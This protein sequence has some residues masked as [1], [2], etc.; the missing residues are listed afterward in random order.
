MEQITSLTKMLAV[1]VMTE[2]G[3][4]FCV[5]VLFIYTLLPKDIKQKV[6]GKL[7]Y[8]FDYA[9]TTLLTA[10]F[11]AGIVYLSYPNYLDHLES[12]ITSLGTVLSH[13]ES[14]YPQ[15][16]FYPY[17]GLLYGPLLATIQAFFSQIGLPILFSSKIP[18]LIAFLSSIL[19]CLYLLK[20]QIAKGY[21]IYLAPFGLMLFWNRAEPFFL[22]L[23]STTLLLTKLKNQTNLSFL[24]AG[25]LTGLASALKLHG[26]FYILSAYLVVLLGITI[27]T[28]GLL[29]FFASS[30]VAFLIFFIP[31]NISLVNFFTYLKL[32]STH[33]ISYKLWV[34]N[35][36]YFIFLVFPILAMWDKI[37]SNKNISYKIFTVI[38]IE[39]L[40]TF[41][42]AK[43][44][45]G[46][47]HMLPF[48]PVNAY[49][50]YRLN[51][52]LDVPCARILKII[53]FSL[54]FP[55]V[56]AIATVYTPL[57]KTW[58]DFGGAI[59]ELQSFN[60]EYPGLVM[61]ITDYKNYPYTFLR[62]VLSGT[63]ID[64]ASYMD[65]QFAGV[66]DSTM[67]KKME[68]CTIKYI[69]LPKD[70]I[71]FSTIN[72]YTEEYLFSLK[73]QQCFYAQYKPI[74][75]RVYFNIYKCTNKD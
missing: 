5:T 4:F 67:V 64:Y 58:N 73:I 41:I 17:H 74:E 44:G 59:K 33:G 46:I 19:I 23:V 48:V 20:N 54:I 1:A 71:P 11:I 75:N 52:D 45:A 24:I 61:G 3:T 25:I 2:R 70:G 65:L 7:Q 28:T 21:L 6:F 37:I 42:G 63:Q 9:A 53:Y 36:I 18:G 12:S 49:L 66:S 27:T 13:G 15:P 43:P 32:A 34:I 30:A 14:L 72:P 60:N 26:I 16:D 50:I 57:I 10:I 56:F 8:R 68:D 51:P 62:A 47:H 38:L 22:L 55:S 40:I 69:I 35:I 31:P 29:V 39:F